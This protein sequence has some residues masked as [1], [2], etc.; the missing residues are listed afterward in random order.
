MPHEADRNLDP[1]QFRAL[2][3]RFY[4][5]RPYEYVSLRL[6]ALLLTV[7]D[8]PHIESALREGLKF[9]TVE[10][11]DDDIPNT[12]EDTDDLASRRWNYAAM[13]SVV[14]LHQTVESFMRLLFAHL[15][16][17]ACPWL[18]VTG[19][20]NPK[21][22]K[23]QLERLPTDL[24]DATFLSQVLLVMRGHADAAKPPSWCT[25]DEWQQHAEGL[26]MLLSS[27]CQ[28]LL[29]D[30]G[31]Y[32]SAKHG[33][34]VLATWGG[35]G[36][37]LPQETGLDLSHD[38]RCLVHLERQK[39]D[40]RWCWCEIWSW[41]SVEAN[42]GLTHFFAQQMESLWTVARVRYLGDTS[43]NVIGLKP[44]GLDLVLKAGRGEGPII[45]TT[46]TFPLTYFID[47]QQGI[48]AP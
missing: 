48:D 6:R 9:G 10:L 21:A 36:I 45:F 30:A 8:S 47:K 34:A 46:A 20:T 37:G 19:Q 28:L 43:G 42:L 31:R 5:G 32:N 27:G 18:A 13:E 16:D 1:R 17:P 29:D 3:E 41:E 22:F 26:R 33:L 11:R 24:D 12:G 44:E 4:M 15:E 14:L 35:I 39:R 38:G 7:S 23:R 40:G 2:N 25:E